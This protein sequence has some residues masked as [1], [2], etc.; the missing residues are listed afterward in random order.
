M[1]TIVAGQRAAT[2][3]E[4]AELALGVDTDLSAAICTQVEP[5]VFFPEQ[6]D[7]AGERVAK[8]ICGF[9]PVRSACLALAISR[10]EEFGIFGGLTPQERRELYPVRRS[11]DRAAVEPTPAPTEPKR[12]PVTCGS[13]RGYQRHRRR[14]EVA[15]D[16]C[17]YANAAADRRL[18]TTGSTKELAA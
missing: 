5:D 11:V 1:K 2:A 14:G 13:R 17:R 4:F 16:L 18:R 3:F 8:E 12:E 10:N 6:E 7:A 15:C 9:C